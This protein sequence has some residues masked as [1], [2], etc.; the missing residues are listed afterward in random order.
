MEGAAKI[1]SLLTSTQQA[2]LRMRFMQKCYMP[3]YQ[4]YWICNKSKRTHY[5][6]SLAKDIE[7]VNRNH[8]EL[9][10]AGL[11]DQRL[12]E[13]WTRKRLTEVNFVDLRSSNATSVLLNRTK[14]LWV[15]GNMS[16]RRL[17]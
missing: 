10:L 16:A 13:Y 3:A 14:T 12:Q 1:S 6:A 15:S 4:K 17:K 2:L 11:K 9:Y 8:H 7:D 5:S